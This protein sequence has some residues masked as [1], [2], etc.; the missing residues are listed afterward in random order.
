MLE[1]PKAGPLAA[2]VASTLSRIVATCVLSPTRSRP[3]EP[4]EDVEVEFREPGGPPPLLPAQAPVSVAT[5][6][7]RQ[8]TDHVTSR[9]RA[10]GQDCFRARMLL[11]GA[12][13]G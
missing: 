12:I 8:T 3:S 5:H 2:L 7:A 1:M 4:A 13:T 10:R 11:A 9:R 6:S